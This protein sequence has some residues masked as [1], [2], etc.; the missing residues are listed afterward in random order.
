MQWSISMRPHSF[1]EMYGC[2]NVKKYFY[3]VAEKKLDYPAI[4][5]FQG[6]FGGGKTTSAKILAQMISCTNPKEN[7]DPCCECPSCKAIIDETWNM[8]CIQFDSSKGGKDEVLDLLEN[9]T[10]RP[11]IRGNHKKVMI[12]E[13]AQELSTKAQNTLL[14][15]T[16]RPQ[17]NIYFI[18]TAME[19]LTPGGLTTRCVKFMFEGASQ[20]DLIKYQADVLT[21]IGLFNKKEIIGDLDPVQFWGPL[22]GLIASNSYGS[23][24]DA[25]QNLNE[26]IVA[27]I[28]DATKAMSFFNFTDTDTL[29]K[30]LCDLMEGKA[31]EITF[32]TLFSGYT[33]VKFIQIYRNILIPAYEYKA[34][35][36][37]NALLGS[38]TNQLISNKNFS[39]LVSIYEQVLLKSPN[40]T[41]DPPPIPLDMYKTEICRFADLCKLNPQ[42]VNTNDAKKASRTP[43]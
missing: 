27:D 19:P 40:P 1:N 43:V 28:F 2:D 16:E 30:A 14:K 17:N 13:E 33:A 32:N 42:G 26:C 25:I 4:T 23:Y 41:K 12:I 22:L 20:L 8:D 18:L 38:Y 36:I 15:V 11:S 5:L 9:F 37:K 24:R 35:K 34:F 3:K 21:K 6:K 7:G 31:N 10:S 29:G 39:N